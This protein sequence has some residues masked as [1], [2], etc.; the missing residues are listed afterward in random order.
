MTAGEKTSGGDGDDH[1]SIQRSKIEWNAE[2]I[3][4]AYLLNPH[5]L[6][7]YVFMRF[8]MFV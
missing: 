5:T 2:G 1:T 4:K 7:M 8:N 3:I 6:V